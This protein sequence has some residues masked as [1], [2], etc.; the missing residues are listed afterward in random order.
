MGSRSPRVLPLLL[1]LLLLLFFGFA[2]LLL[3]DEL[4]LPLLL[5]LSLSLSKRGLFMHAWIEADVGLSL[6]VG[7]D[8]SWVD[9]VV[10]LRRG[11]AGWVE[12]GWKGGR[13]AKLHLFKAGHGAHAIE[14]ANLIK[15]GVA[16]G[17]EAWVARLAKGAKACH[18]AGRDAGL[19]FEAG[20]LM[21]GSDRGLV[22]V[23]DVQRHDGAGRTG[24]CGYSLRVG[25]QNRRRHCV[26]VDPIVHLRG[27]DALVGGLREAH[28]REMCGGHGCWCCKVVF[29]QVCLRNVYLQACR[30]MA[31]L[32][33]SRSPGRYA[34][35]EGSMSGCV[36]VE[37]KVKGGEVR[38]RLMK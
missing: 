25:R 7:G 1:L 14:H 21:A 31:R 30:V 12:E 22:I 34:D 5:R 10:G 23:R 20:I 2:L 8:G 36:M 27:I 35:G 38:R 6:L 29:F 19:L 17:A 26:K 15:A 28:G 33:C 13:R 37:K 11:V 9:K 3:L 4:L 24:H 32:T 16:E 18:R